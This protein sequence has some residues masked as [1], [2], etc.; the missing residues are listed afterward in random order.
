MPSSDATRS[1]P[2]HVRG[3]PVH[4]PLRVAWAGPSIHGASGRLPARFPSF[5]GA[6]RIKESEVR[7]WRAL[8]RGWCSDAYPP[9][10]RPPGPGRWRVLRPQRAV[11]GT[12]ICFP[13]LRESLGEV[14]ARCCDRGA[15]P[16]LVA[17]HPT[18]KPPWSSPL[19]SRVAGEALPCGSRGARL[20][21]RA[22]Q[23]PPTLMLRAGPLR[24]GVRRCAHT[25][26]S[27][28]RDDLDVGTSVSR[29]G[30]WETAG[31]FLL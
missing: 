30:R 4:Q 11:D 31:P 23:R 21:G 8:G 2:H 5:R 19:A 22:P 28:R 7:T 3:W 10:S 29:S 1:S 17:R 25:Q 26:R 6:P 16:A 27:L 9:A 18:T 24:S 20:A 12:A 13:R 15:G 14:A